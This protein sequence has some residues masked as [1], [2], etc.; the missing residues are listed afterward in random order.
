[1]SIQEE[2]EDQ[3]EN[4][5]SPARLVES[6]RDTGYTFST[7][8]ADVI[9]N[10]IAARATEVRITLTKQY[11]GSA[12]LLIADNGD[13]MDE[14]GVES[15]MKYGSPPRSS[16]KSLG[17]FGMG[18]KTAST[19]QCRKLTLLSKKEGRCYI[20]QW[21]LDVIKNTDK[22]T[23][24]K[25]EKRRYQEYIDFLEN[26]IQEGNGTLVIWENID[27]ILRAETEGSGSRQIEKISND[28]KAY[29]SGVFF[30]FLSGNEGYNSVRISIN[31]EYIAPYDPLCRW[32]NTETGKRL[33]VHPNSLNITQKVNGE[34]KTIGSFYLNV[35]I[36]P[37]KN[38]L[39]PE[40][41]EKSRYSLDQQGFH[42]F[43]E[44]RM[45]ASGGWHKLFVKE[46]HMNL[47][48]V[49]LSFDHELD[50]FFQIDIKKSRIDFP[51]GRR[52][53]IK[54]MIT[55]AIREAKNRYRK[56]SKISSD[57]K[58][59]LEKQHAKSSSAINRHHDLITSGSK[60]NEV[61]KQKGEAKIQNKFGYT[62]VRLIMD[63]STDKVVQTVDSLQ[64]GALWM[65]GL[66]DGNKHAVFINQSHEFYK[67]FYYPLIDNQALV[68]AMDSILWSL[69]EA[70]MSVLTDSVKRNIEELRISV[71]RILRTMA[72][73]LPE[74]EIS[75]N[76][77]PE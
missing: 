43:R 6:L 12:T 18:L 22:W 11:D 16:N 57:R 59:D 60:V 36:L 74:I 2:Y 15:A 52:K 35:Y 31:G 3:K 17:K 10:S 61:D 72:D 40:E 76:E 23:L 7:A 28:L 1:M 39:S 9:D 71:S 70:E 19:S 69:A 50:D 27:R 14:A 32:L 29:L 30:N 55:P 68:L 34:T 67:R 73:E 25:P 42:V 5:P 47:V 53:E 44:G 13:G 26:L 54:Q 46:P 63:D 77:S 75:E 21:N 20:R 48:R 51:H 24:L 66:I 45:I 65:P 62:T 56:G 37:I 41:L 8:V 4:I 38:E 49:E 33:D 58:T 64:D